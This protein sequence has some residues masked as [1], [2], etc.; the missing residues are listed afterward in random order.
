MSSSR[1]SSV[2]LVLIVLLAALWPVPVRAQLVFEAVGERALGMGGAFVAVADDATAVHWNPAGLVAGQPAGATL[3]WHRFRVGDDGV[4]PGAGQSRGQSSLTSLGTW[5]LGVS[6]GTLG[7]QWVSGS[8]GQVR[9]HAVRISHLGLTV[10]QSVTSRVVIGSTLK[11]MRGR[12]GTAVIDEAT[13]GDV[14]ENLRDLD[15]DGEMAFDLDLGVLVMGRVVSVGVVSK[16]LRSPAFGDVAETAIALPRQ[17]RAGVSVRPADG[18]ILALDVDLDTVDLMGESRQMLAAGGEV[19]VGPRV[20]IRSGART[21]L[22]QS[23]QLIGSIGASVAV[24]SGMWIDGHYSR[25]REDGSRELGVALRA[26]F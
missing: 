23:G 17:M 16:N 25:G 19:A 8:E 18:L 26:G 2:L 9:G 22:A 10:L 7:Q 21:N 1:V 6:Y 15:L 11:F 20:R 4:A 3:G 14:F 12:A 13:A 24:R 5:P